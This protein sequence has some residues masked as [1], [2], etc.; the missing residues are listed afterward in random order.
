MI[1]VLMLDLGNTLVDQNS[2]PFPHVA[3]ALTAIAA[4]KTEA[5]NPLLSCL[6]SDFHLATP[7]TPQNVKARFAEYLAILDTTTLRPFFEPVSKRITL[8][9]HANAMKPD[10]KIFAKALQRL[11]AVAPLEDCLFITEDAGHIAAARS[12]LH[13]QTLQFGNDFNDWS[14]APALITHLVA[15][16][17]PANAEA[18]IKAHL[19]SHGME[20]SKAG[21]A[22]SGG[23]I[24]VSGHV[25]RPVSI[26]GHAD[27]K[28][29]QVAVPVEGHI[30]Q[31]AKGEYELAEPLSPSPESLEEATHFVRSLAEQGQIAGRPGAFRAS[32]AIETDAEGNRKLVRKRFSA[33]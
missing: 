13:M 16:A 12:D 20:M 26:P 1:Q 15:P 29:V 10:R 3:A 19:A 14:Q 2:H 33:L 8:S 21:S 9:T 18:A 5:G 32:H 6:V 17:H 7:F 23:K 27:L 22:G 25:W 11:G 31:G 24:P 30:S 28:D 4:F